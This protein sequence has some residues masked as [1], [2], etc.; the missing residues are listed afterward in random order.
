MLVYLLDRVATSV[1]VGWAAT[2]A[3]GRYY[4]YPVV[5]DDLATLPPTARVYVD[6][7]RHGRV[8]AA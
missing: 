3:R 7:R 5:V 2:H 1:W 6:G 4:E 8:A